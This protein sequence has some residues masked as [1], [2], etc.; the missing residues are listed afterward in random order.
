M[1]LPFLSCPSLFCK[2][3][4]RN[5]RDRPDN[6]GRV[7]A[8]DPAEEKTRIEVNN[9]VGASVGALLCSSRAASGVSN[10]LKWWRLLNLL[11]EKDGASRPAPGRVNA[12]CTA[13]LECYGVT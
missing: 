11:G 8:P 4:L 10:N 1:L 9:S 3:R 5:L 12:F 13:L 7:L 2:H 6:Q